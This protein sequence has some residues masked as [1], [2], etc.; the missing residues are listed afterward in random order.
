MFRQ[1]ISH[2]PSDGCPRAWAP[3]SSGPAVTP[4]GV[5]GRAFSIP[6]PTP[7]PPDPQ[8]W[9][10]T[11]HQAAH[12]LWSFC[13]GQLALP[14]DKP[15]QPADP[16]RGRVRPSPEPRT[17]AAEGPGPGGGRYLPPCPRRSPPTGTP[18]RGAPRWMVR[19]LVLSEGW[20]QRPGKAPPTAPDPLAPL[21]AGSHLRAFALPGVYWALFPRRHRPS[22]SQTRALPEL[23]QRGPPNLPATQGTTVPC[24]LRQVCPGGRPRALWSLREGWKE[25]R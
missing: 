5:Q 14:G 12:S 6:V 13:S 24:P 3:P 16:G 21:G 18:P 17:A 19:R 9:P 11:T 1:T 7:A 4:P 22:P 20:G 15:E 25:R 23:P 10:S 2:G 8:A